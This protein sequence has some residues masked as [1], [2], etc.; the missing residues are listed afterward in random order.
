MPSS[1]YAKFRIGQTT[2]DISTVGQRSFRPNDLFRIN[3]WTELAE[4]RDRFDEFYIAEMDSPEVLA[5]S[6]NPT[7][8]TLRK[9][10]VEKITK[11]ISVCNKCEV[12]TS[13]LKAASDYDLMYTVRGGQWPTSISK[14]GPGRP[15]KDPENPPPGFCDYGHE[16]NWY[17]R[18][19]AK[20]WRC[21]T[22]RA[23]N[24]KN[25]EERKKA[26]LKAAGKCPKG[27]DDWRVYQRSNRDKPERQCRVCYREAEAL[28][29]EKKKAA[30]VESRNG[31]RTSLV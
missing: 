28:R 16:P 6:E 21:N 5:I 17:Y 30:V 7:V 29:R 23:E 8:D 19:D 25:R 31:H 14:R 4:C 1:N 22:C 2:S 13:C 26:A 20:L 9:V 18:K 11:A 3:H 27:H 10:N 24:W 12:K 15:R